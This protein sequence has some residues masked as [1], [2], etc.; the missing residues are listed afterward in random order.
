MW[1]CLTKY[2]RVVAVAAATQMMIDNTRTGD[3]S[4]IQ[5]TP[6]VTSDRVHSTHATTDPALTSSF[7]SRI[8]TTC[9][10]CLFR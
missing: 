3:E 10:H 2:V 9:P 1:H 7:I 8:T 5:P 4:M 6:H